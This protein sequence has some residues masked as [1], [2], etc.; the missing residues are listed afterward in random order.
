MEVVII[1][2]EDLA[3]DS[4]EKLLLQTPY[5]LVIKKRLES[6]SEAIDWF[7]THHCD[8]IFSDVS[9][10]DGDSFEI[11]EALK[12]DIPII[13]TTAFDHYAIQSFQFQAIDYLLKPYNRSNLN[14]ALEKFFSVTN[15]KQTT[16]DSQNLENLINHLSTIPEINKYQTRFLIS[17][18]DALVSINSEE[19][20]Y[21]MA[22]NKSL[23]L[24]TRKGEVFLYDDTLSNLEKKLSPRDFFKVNRKFII[25][26]NSI[27]SIIKYSQ[28]RLK[29]ELQPVP[30]F[31][32]PILISAKNIQS[33]K[34]WLNN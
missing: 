29:V 21:F 3:A 31:N 15:R 23:F 26:H 7:R 14:R 34:D 27:K 11:F 25:R 28:S 8:L 33:F 22:D 9:L 16:Q 32:D 19:I 18:G 10:G 13:F 24:F 12:I 1:E 5:D 17:K 4:L 2:D 6:V 20:A 30:S